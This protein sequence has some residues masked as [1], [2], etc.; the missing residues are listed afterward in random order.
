MKKQILTV[1]L[2]AGLISTI[3]Y[4]RGGYQGGGYTNYNQSQSQTY[5]GTIADTTPLAELTQLQED[6][7]LYMYEEEKVA[8]DVYRTL[9]DMW[10]VSTFYRIQNAEQTHMDTIGTLLDK[11]SIDKPSDDTTGVFQNQDLQALY[12]QLV[13]QGSTSVEDALEVG[14][15]VEE[16]DIADLEAKIVNT[17]SDISAIYQRLLN[18]SYNHLSAFNRALDSAS[19]QTY[20]SNNY[21]YYGGRGSRR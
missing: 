8:R 11:Y 6:D 1:A 7:L 9:G 19:Y 10:G 14:I 18:G 3:S 16:T 17:P 12:N 13:E 21:L 2:C 15:L 20:N 5:V 4:G